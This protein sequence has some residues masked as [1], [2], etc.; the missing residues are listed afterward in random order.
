MP[1]AAVEKGITRIIAT[2]HHR[3]GRY[4]NPKW[5]ILERVGRL[6]K[7]LTEKHP[8]NRVA[9]ATNLDL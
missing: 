1:K 4:E 2:P 5:D 6:N 9:G 7:V 8:V 3:N